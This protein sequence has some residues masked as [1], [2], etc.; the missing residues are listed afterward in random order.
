MTSTTSTIEE[1]V[2][3]T[4]QSRGQGSYLSYAAPVVQALVEREQG[5]S[6]TL[7]EKATEADLD[8]DV[9]AFLTEIGLSV[10]PE[11]EPEPEP[12]AATEDEG[13]LAAIRRMLGSLAEKVEAMTTFARRHGFNG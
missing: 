1:T 6:A 11:P 9:K 2:Q 12:E 3:S 5:I 10:T 8:F 4:L 13:D 7:I